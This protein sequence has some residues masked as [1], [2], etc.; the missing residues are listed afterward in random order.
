[1]CC[2]TLLQFQRL[3]FVSKYDVDDDR[4]AEEGADGRDGQGV[5]EDGADEVAE[6]QDVRPDESG[7]GQG[8]TVV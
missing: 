1:M 8:E 2:V 7:G 5:G 4:C 6:Q 3:C